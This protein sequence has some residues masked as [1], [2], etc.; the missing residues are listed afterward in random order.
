MLYNFDELSFSV[1]SVERFTHKKGSFSVKARPYAALSFRTGGTGAF[2][3]S[4]VEFISD[5]GDIVFIPA[6][7]PY[8]VNYSVSESIVVHFSECNYY[9]TEHIRIKSKALVSLKFS[10]MLL[11]WSDSHSVNR[12]KADIYDILSTVEND[13]RTAITNEA[14]ESCIRYID[15]NFCDPSLTVESA[16]ELS[17]ISVSTLQRAFSKHFGVSPKQYLIK[18]RMNKAIELLT[19]TDKPIKEISFECGICDEK[20]FSRIF[21]RIYGYS[22]SLLKGGRNV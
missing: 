11:H 15:L 5:E 19:N 13:K 6:N 7:T 12:A 17:F 8:E 10:Q 1:L 16:C 20:Y 22:P 18:L 14:V 9:D 3:V 2:K 21:R 4:G